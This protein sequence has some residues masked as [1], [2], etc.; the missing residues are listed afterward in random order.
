MN[1]HEC[2]PPRSGDSKHNG[3]LNRIFEAIRANQVLVGGQDNLWKQLDPL[4]AEDP[5]DD[6]RRQS[7]LEKY[8]EILQELRIRIGTLLK[9]DNVSFLLGAGASMDAGGVSLAWI[10]FEVEYYLLEKGMGGKTPANW[11]ILFYDI[12]AAITDTP[13]VTPSQ[14]RH[15]VSRIVDGHRPKEDDYLPRQ[16]LEQFLTILHTWQAAMI[17]ETLT[18][19]VGNKQELSISHSDLR[20]LIMHLTE[21]LTKAC[22]LPLEDKHDA[23]LTHRRLLKKVLTRPLNLRRVNLFTLNY[24]TLLEQAADAEGV[25]LVDGFVGTLRRVFRPESFDQDFYFPAQTTEG[26]VH[27]LDRVLHLYKLH[28]SITWHREDPSWEN[29]YGLYATFFNETVHHDDVLIYPTPLKH[30]QVL[31]LPYSELFRRLASYLVQPQSVLFVIGYGFGDEHVNTLIRQA[32][33]VPSFTLVVV[34]P[35]PQNDFVN[36]LEQLGDQ[37]VWLVKGK[38]NDDDRTLWGLGTFKGFVEHLLPDLREEEIQ[39]KVIETYNA[40][41][42][43]KPTESSPPGGG[44]DGE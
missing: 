30:G 14:R 6:E 31:G 1:E 23:L 40:L 28:G 5:Q 8:P 13:K 3:D 2:L 9:M 18:V 38:G 21:A 27:R 26:R 36:Q 15:T 17:G 25:V 44:S 33:S 11:L 32:L 24:D 20:N 16:N 22:L 29:P 41:D 43:R 10:P 19:S 42:F 4:L 39:Q 35:N 34:D 7:V 12:L 37:R